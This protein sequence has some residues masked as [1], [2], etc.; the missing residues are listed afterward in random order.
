MQDVYMTYNRCMQDAYELR[1]LTGDEIG[2]RADEFLELYQASF[3]EPPWDESPDSAPTFAE[4]V[5]FQLRT[6]PGM[7]GISAEVDGRLA[8]LVYGWPAAEAFPDTSFYRSLT[9]AIPPGTQRQLLAPAL[10]VVHLMVGVGQRGKGIGR[11][12]LDEYVSGWPTAWLCTHPEAPARHLY[13]SMG[14]HPI[15]EFLSDPDAPRVVYTK[16]PS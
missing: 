4:R 2:A 6:Y 1:K 11:A 8:G 15:G 12:L 14:W 10:E 9:A 3:A 16:A 7:S 13:D 5:A